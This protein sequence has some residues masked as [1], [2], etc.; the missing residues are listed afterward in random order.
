MEGVER[1]GD[2]RSGR[3]GGGRKGEVRAKNT[4]CGQTPDAL[5]VVTKK[6]AKR[7]QCVHH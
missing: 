6:S 4:S 3:G 5:R 7:V 2:G 1:R